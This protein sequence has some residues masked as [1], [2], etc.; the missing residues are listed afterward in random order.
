[1]HNSMCRIQAT[2]VSGGFASV[3]LKAVGNLCYPFNGIG[4]HSAYS[5]IVPLCKYLR[6]AL[7]VIRMFL[8]GHSNADLTI[9]TG[10]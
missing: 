3:E 9:T 10:N 6:T 7:Y 2:R 4:S 1:M 8:T 5:T